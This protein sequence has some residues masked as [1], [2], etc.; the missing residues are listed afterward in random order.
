M[1]FEANR[2]LLFSDTLVS[3]IFITEYMADADGDY[4]KV[5]LY[6]LFLAK[7]K[8]CVPINDLAKKLGIEVSKVEQAF[9]YWE[10]A[11]VFLRK[12]RGIVIC[13]LKEKEVHKLYSPKLT[14][15]EEA[16]QSY[17][18][19]IKRTQVIN[20]INN[21][22]FQGVMAPGW[23]LDINEWFE[24]YGFEEEVMFVLFKHCF[25]KG[26][27]RKSYILAVAEDWYSKGIKSY[28][29]LENYF[30][31]YEKLNDMKKKI[32]KKLG[33]SRRL[34][35][36]EEAYIEKWIN[37]YGFDFEI[38]ELAL[39][40][41]T[42]TS[43]PSFDYINTILTEWKEKGL[44]RVEDIQNHLKEFQEKKRNKKPEI[45]LKNKY[46]GQIKNIDFSK[47]YD[48]LNDDLNENVGE[49]V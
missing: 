18:K 35:E 27:M 37:D 26:R 44:K 22:F 47:F 7:Y 40:K 5:Y 12:E 31:Q 45:G 21:C 32:R 24:K 28:F 38:I 6:C 15:P 1:D 11:G 20:A 39:K 41:T 3:D 49:K 36:Y 29:D 4:V 9:A 14:A 43:N 46:F 34:S 42:S 17:E 10:N 25:D 30:M 16:K 48:N 2:T 13:D 23:Y 33:I 8:K 19:N